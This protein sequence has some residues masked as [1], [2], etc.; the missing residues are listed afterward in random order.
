MRKNNII[1]RNLFKVEKIL[2][3]YDDKDH[4]KCLSN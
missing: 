1:H 4:K 2:I 3:K